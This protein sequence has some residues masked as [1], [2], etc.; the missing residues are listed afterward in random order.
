MCQ[1]SYVPY[2][3][4]IILHKEKKVDSILVYTLEIEYSNW[5]YSAKFFWT[6]LCY[7]HVFW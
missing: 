7:S 2:I 4:Y 3:A 1:W 5:K 6:H